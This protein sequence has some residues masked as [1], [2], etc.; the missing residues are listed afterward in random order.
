L[1]KNDK[2]CFKKQPL[3][4]FGYRRKIFCQHRCVTP[5]YGKSLLGFFHLLLLI[6]QPPKA[7]NGI[8]LGKRTSLLLLRFFLLPPFCRKCEETVIPPDFKAGSASMF[9]NKTDALTFSQF[10]SICPVN[11][12]CQQQ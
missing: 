2:G 7:G 9:I 4:F 1:L 5:L 11:L 3:S 10:L 8:T 12:C 6:A